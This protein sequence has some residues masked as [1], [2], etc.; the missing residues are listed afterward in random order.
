MRD[1][2]KFNSLEELIEQLTKDKLL[3]ENE[4]MNEK[5]ENFTYK[6]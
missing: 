2:F 5:I 6:C 1:E 3:V 4:E